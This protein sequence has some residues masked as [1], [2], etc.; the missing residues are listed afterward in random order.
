MYIKSNHPHL[1]RVY[2]AV[3]ERGWLVMEL[4]VAGSLKSLLMNSDQVVGVKT[5]MRLAA[6]TAAGVA[7]LHMTDVRRQSP[8]PAPAT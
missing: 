5:Q 7:Y 8:V 2:G 3:P 6:E 4:C 1:L